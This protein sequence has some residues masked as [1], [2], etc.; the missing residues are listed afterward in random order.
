MASSNNH[1]NNSNSHPD[2]PSIKETTN[3]NNPIDSNTSVL[4][5]TPGPMFLDFLY[6]GEV[7]L[8]ITCSLVKLI[9]LRTKLMNIL[10]SD[11]RQQIEE[12]SLLSKLSIS[13]L[14][15]NKDKIDYDSTFT[16][17]IS[18][19]P[20]MFGMELFFIKNYFFSYLDSNNIILVNSNNKTP[21]KESINKHNSDHSSQRKNSNNNQD[22]KKGS[23]LTKVEIEVSG[24]DKYSIQQEYINIFS[25]YFSYKVS[26]SK[27]SVYKMS[28]ESVY[29][30]D[31]N[32][33]HFHQMFKDR[34]K[35]YVERFE[36]QINNTLETLSQSTES[37]SGLIR[38]SL[39]QRTQIFKNLQFNTANP[40]PQKKEEKSNEQTLPHF[41]SEI[42]ISNKPIIT[43]DGSS[44]D[45]T[46]LLN[47]YRERTKSS[48]HHSVLSSKKNLTISDQILHT[49]QTLKE[50][51]RKKRSLVKEKEKTLQLIGDV[52][53]LNNYD[54]SNTIDY[55]YA[56]RPTTSAFIRKQNKD[57]YK[58]ERSPVKKLSLKGSVSSYLKRK[59]SIIRTESINKS[60][61]PS[62]LNSDEMEERLKKV[63]KSSSSVYLFNNN[64]IANSSSKRKS[65]TVTNRER[66]SHGS[67]LKTP[68]LSAE[69]YYINRKSK[70]IEDKEE[71]VDR[72]NVE[73]GIAEHKH[74]K[75]LTNNS[76]LFTNKKGLL[77]RYNSQNS[78]SKDKIIKAQKQKEKLKQEAIKNVLLSRSL[79]KQGYQFSVASL[80]NLHTQN[81]NSHRDSQ[82]NSTL[83]HSTIFSSPPIN[84]NT[85]NNCTVNKIA[86]HAGEL[87]VVPKV[88]INRGSTID[89][90]SVL[91]SSGKQKSQRTIYTHTEKCCH[92]ET[93]KEK[94]NVLNS[95]NNKAKNLH[96][97]NS[98]R[99]ITESG[100]FCN[101]ELISKQEQAVN[102]RIFDSR[103]RAEA[104]KNKLNKNV[105]YNFLFDI[106]PK[107]K[108]IKGKDLLGAIDNDNDNDK[109]KA[110]DSSKS[111]KQVSK[112]Y[113]QHPEHYTLK[114]FKNNEEAH[115]LENPFRMKPSRSTA[116][117]LK[118][119]DS[120]ELEE[121]IKNK[122]ID[123][124]SLKEVSQFK[125]KPLLMTG[126][127]QTLTPIGSD[128]FNREY[129]H[130]SKGRQKK[131]LVNLKG[132]TDNRKGK[133]NEF[134]NSSNKSKIEANKLGLEYKTISRRGDSK[135]HIEDTVTDLQKK[136]IEYEEDM[137]NA[138]SLN[139]G[140]L[141]SN[142]DNQMLRNMNKKSIQSKRIHD[143]QPPNSL[144]VNS[145]G[146][147][148]LSESKFDYLN[149]KKEKLKKLSV[150]ENYNQNQFTFH[151]KNSSEPESKASNNEHNSIYHNQTEDKGSTV[152]M[153]A[154]FSTI[155]RYNKVDTMK[156]K[157]L[158]K[159]NKLPIINNSLN[160]LRMKELNKKIRIN[161]YQNNDLIR[162][163]VFNRN[164]EEKKPKATL[165]QNKH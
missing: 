104:V 136:T 82:D 11:I 16:L 103:I 2:N 12:Q 157:G 49:K 31:I 59:S 153:P 71:P 152:N 79:S 6:D 60:N 53:A 127:E 149:L 141:V 123:K 7:E 108:V 41:Y 10:N 1:S 89:I 97:S 121:T 139:N 32:F 145:K 26:S 133:I 61:Q 111:K 128:I 87:I 43:N 69:Q 161:F 94:A 92:K 73:E 8:T 143:I 147:D 146:N 63:P 35:L 116:S 33:T 110:K 95:N 74:L 156:N 135:V 34:I 100:I 66:N 142:N 47:N 48:K 4:Y 40:N 90:E 132:S 76:E 24:Q 124:L 64:E 117:V 151:N 56:L 72:K 107:N 67:R 78:S 30:D 99:N 3:I 125:E 158:N 164:P 22:N 42:N 5:R 114:T 20:N 150:S 57:L 154:R 137:I 51:L 58:K 46:V 140:D 98:N 122:G 162:N 119:D 62:F 109:D 160:L 165:F 23:T 86:D 112:N 126:S 134:I 113:N 25:K 36:F 55:D 38:N 129:S 75:R 83:V 50:K 131:H 19:R 88:I 85:S 91:N 106:K 84:S 159:N 9:Q 68:F 21:A 13:T 65:K 118:K 102:R 93:I 27:A 44:F 130:L 45:R 81:K 96:L 28:F 163:I 14:L 138:N 144:N 52:S 115:N 155:E 120:N 70:T 101:T 39:R 54:K 18:R 17:Q 15:K 80:S 105:F 148:G 37:L 77:N 29:Q